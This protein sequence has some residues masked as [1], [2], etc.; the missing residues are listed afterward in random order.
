VKQWRDENW[1][2][3]E[4]V[5]KTCP[6]AASLTTILTWTCLGLNS[7]L[8]GERPVINYLDVFSMIGTMASEPSEKFGDWISQLTCSVFT[9]RH[10]LS[11]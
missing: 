3:T 2:R 9:A 8:R 1:Q 5:A 6:S 10:E 7:C 4:I 11:L